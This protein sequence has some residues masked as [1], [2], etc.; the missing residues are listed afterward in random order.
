MRQFGAIKKAS[1]SWGARVR[2]IEAEEIVSKEV[3]RF[4]HEAD[5]HVVGVILD[6]NDVVYDRSCVYTPAAHIEVGGNSKP[7]TETS[8]IH[9]FLLHHYHLRVCRRLLCRRPIRNQAASG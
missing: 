8:P 9:D 4:Q 7:P 2:A 1:A 3:V 6:P 5:V